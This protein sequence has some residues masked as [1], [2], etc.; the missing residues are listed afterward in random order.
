MFILLI[1]ASKFQK[2]YKKELLF[3]KFKHSI[4]SSC[5]QKI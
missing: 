3:L 2:I 1:I 4:L 5:L